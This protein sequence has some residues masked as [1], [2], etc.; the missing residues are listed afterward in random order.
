MRIVLF[1]YKMGSVSAK[2]LAEG[3]GIRRIFPNKNYKPTPD[4][5]VINW[6]NS[7]PTYPNSITWDVSIPH[8]INQ[9]YNVSRTV[10]KSMAFTQL[11][12]FVPI[13]EYTNSRE[14]AKEWLDDGEI[15]VVRHMETG[16]GAQGIELVFPDQD[17]L[18]LAPLYTKYRKKKDEYRVHVFG[19][20]VIDVTQKKLSIKKK[21]AGGEVNFKVRNLEGGWIYT[22]KGVDPPQQVLTNAVIAVSA[23]GLKFGAVD[24]GWNEHHQEALVYEVNTAPGITGTTL[25]RYIKAFANY[26]DIS[27][28]KYFPTGDDIEVNSFVDVQEDYVLKVDEGEETPI[29]D[30]DVEGSMSEWAK[31]FHSTHLDAE[32]IQK[33]LF[34]K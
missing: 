7:I 15:V 17:H 21:K 1:P 24:I 33:H 5:I 22:R 30:E 16:Y 34:N 32:E 3:L 26:F 25:N 27:V 4:D 12:G 6:G 23:M 18:P 10:N 14:M 9:L 20:K 2:K 13:P 29:L 19:G 28:K 31:V 8:I 11:E